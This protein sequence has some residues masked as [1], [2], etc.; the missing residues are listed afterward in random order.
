MATGSIREVFARVRALQATRNQRCGEVRTEPCGHR[1]V[2]IGHSFG[3]LVAYAAVHQF[4]VGSASESAAP[5]GSQTTLSSLWRRGRENLKAMK[6][7]ARQIE[8][9]SVSPIGPERPRACKMVA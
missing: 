6:R 8:R 4:L 3:A 9:F 7:A 2:T 5:S 1:L